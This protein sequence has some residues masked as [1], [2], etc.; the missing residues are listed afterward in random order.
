M[1]IIFSLPSLPFS[2]I[3]AQFSC[4]DFNNFSA[5][6]STMV[7]IFEKAADSVKNE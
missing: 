5:A 4:N 6:V 2:R 1:E 7:T 3:T